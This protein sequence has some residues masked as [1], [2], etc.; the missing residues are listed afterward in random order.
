[1]VGVSGLE[2]GVQDELVVEGDVVRMLFDDGKCI[3][4]EK[5]SL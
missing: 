4:F 5:H 1:M 2:D 3:L